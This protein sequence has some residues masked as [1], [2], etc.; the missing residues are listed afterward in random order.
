MIWKKIR[1][2]LLIISW[3]FSL[4]IRSDITLSR[5]SFVQSLLMV[6]QGSWTMTSPSPIDMLVPENRFDK[7]KF[8]LHGFMSQKMI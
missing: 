1:S 7:F 5:D 4:D 6:I 3:W 8:F 2:I